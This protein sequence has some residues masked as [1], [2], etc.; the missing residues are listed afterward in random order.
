[1]TVPWDVPRLRSCEKVSGA[2]PLDA[3]NESQ[4]IAG[5]ALANEAPAANGGPRGE[6]QG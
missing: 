2:E 4:P 1:M 5:V 6:W 3:A